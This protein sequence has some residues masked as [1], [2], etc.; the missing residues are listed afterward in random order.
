MFLVAR[1]PNKLVAFNGT[2]LKNLTTI[3]SLNGATRSVEIV[4][5]LSIV[6]ENHK[7]LVYL[8]IQFKD[9]EIGGRFI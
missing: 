5:I 6:P 8:K 3:R 4:K 9:P 1:M 2:L 7:G